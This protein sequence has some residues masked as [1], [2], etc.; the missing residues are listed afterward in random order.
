MKVLLIVAFITYN[1]KYNL[2]LSYS[3]KS[4]VYFVIITTCMFWNTLNNMKYLE[5]NQYMDIRVYKES[6]YIKQELRKVKKL[7]IYI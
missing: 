5:R 6:N 4:I 3:K 1:V 7:V 2:Q